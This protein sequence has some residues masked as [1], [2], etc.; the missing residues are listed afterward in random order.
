[1]GH[2][3][4]LSPQKDPFIQKG[5]SWTYKK[6]KKHMVLFFLAQT[7]FHAPPSELQSTE[8][9][10]SSSELQCENTDSYF[11][12]GARGRGERR[13]RFPERLFTWAR[14]LVLWQ[15]WT[16]TLNHLQVAVCRGAV[17]WVAVEQ[18]EERRTREGLLLLYNWG[19]LVWLKYLQE[20]CHSFRL[21]FIKGNNQKGIKR[22]GMFKLVLIVSFVLFFNTKFPSAFKN[23]WTSENNCTYSGLD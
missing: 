6:K 18:T 22:Y 23:I 13:G 5:L 2:L 19:P 15:G 1:M 20:L 11:W 4:S 7:S 17:V 14:W 21:F 9:S 3:T 10:D 12:K 16:V 8:K